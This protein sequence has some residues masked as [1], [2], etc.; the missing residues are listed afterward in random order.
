[1]RRGKFL[2][3]GLLVV[4][5][6]ACGDAEAVITAELEV[7]NP[8][9]EGM[10]VRPVSGMEVLL[11]PFDRDPV[12][13]SLTSAAPNPEPPIPDS[14]LEAQGR[15]AEAQE[16]WR[17]AEA[18]WQSARDNLQRITDEMQGLSRGEARYVALYREFQDLEA[19]L[20]SSERRMN[21]AFERFTEL[22][23]ATIQQAEQVRLLREQWADEAF[24][25]VGEIFAIKLRAA[26]GEAFADTTDAQGMATFE[27]PAGNW[28]V[29]ARQ[30]LPYSEL[31]WNEPVTLE[32]GDPL[33]LTLSRE[34]A[35]VRPK[36]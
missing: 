17:A 8:E 1:M 27:A 14:L 24:A 20:N 31:Y 3:A 12:F 26:G 19:R 6:A 9:G 10:V 13:D 15:V 29:H 23:E 32:R 5:T 22:Q 34:N 33:T 2:A 4:L 36:L 16:Q 11:L 30:E 25:D 35:Q 7:E 18:E 28:W 21:E